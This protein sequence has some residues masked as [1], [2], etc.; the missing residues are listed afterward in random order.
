MVPVLVEPRFHG[1]DGR[2]C[3]EFFDLFP[4]T[5]FRRR[6]IVRMDANDRSD[7][8][9]AIRQDDCRLAGFQC[10]A[11]GQ[12]GLDAC[13]R[14]LLQNRVYFLMECLCIQVTVRINHLSELWILFRR[15]R[16]SA[17]T[18]CPGSGAADFPAS[19]SGVSTSS[20]VPTG[21]M[22]S[23]HA[24]YVCPPSLAGLSSRT[25]KSTI[26]EVRSA[27]QMSTFRLIKL[28]PVSS[29]LYMLLPTKTND[30]FIG[31]DLPSSKNVLIAF[32]Y[33]SFFHFES[34]SVRSSSV[35]GPYHRISLLN[36]SQKAQILIG[37]L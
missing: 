5:W 30:A 1:D 7:R 36:L 24:S 4:V 8:R 17:F 10:C 32:W 25:S 3:G 23:V 2:M 34:R 20:T 22:F 28:F 13:L 12:D 16:G 35:I 9:V 21:G 29:S 14:G 26:G 27:N 33:S 18:I 6:R 11:Y 19:F 37:K 31:L 15:W